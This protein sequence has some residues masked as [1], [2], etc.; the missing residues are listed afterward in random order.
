MVRWVEETRREKWER[1]RG[2]RR[3]CDRNEGEKRSGRTGERKTG[4]GLCVK[5]EG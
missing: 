1:G 5:D 2:A 4:E 3:E